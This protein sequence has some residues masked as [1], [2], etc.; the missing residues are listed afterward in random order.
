MVINIMSNEAALKLCACGCRLPTPN[1]KW[2]NRRKGHVAGQ[3]L[4]FIPGHHNRLRSRPDLRAAFDRDA[5]P[6]PNTGCFIWAGRLLNSGYG[7]FSLDGKTIPAHR[8]AWILE[9]G[10]IDDGREVMHLC[11]RR[12]CVSVAHLRLGTHAEN[13]A[14]K[15]CRGQRRKGRFPYG[16]HR[17][18]SHFSARVSIPGGKGKG[19]H[20]GT[21]PT[22]E[23]AAAVAAQK[24]SE[25][26]A[27]YRFSEAT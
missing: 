16:V 13:M 2:T 8:A 25:L 6:D 9:N 24:R 12:D 7:S 15:Y 5:Y 18:G 14:D 3:P 26:L 17:N 20:L 22:V 1:A 27:E 10:P 11:G 21:Y 4:H 19:L 23:E